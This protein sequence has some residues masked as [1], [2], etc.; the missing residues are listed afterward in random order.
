M[1]VLVTGH[2][3]YVG[4]HVIEVFRNADWIVNGVDTGW[5]N[6]C[7]WADSPLPDEDKIMDFRQLE[8]H[9][10]E[11]FDCIVHLAA[12]SNDALGALDE[13][14]TYDINLRGSIEL[15]QKAK[16][17]GVPR[18]LMAASC[19]V[20]G[21][22][23]HL[24]LDE[25]AP[26]NPLTAYAR[27]KI[28][29]E[30][31][32]SMLA[33]AHFSPAFLRFGTAYGYSP[34]LRLDLVVNNL[35]ASGLTTGEIQIHSDG[36][37]WRPLIHC[38]DMARAFLAFAEAPKDFI[39]NQKINVGSNSENYQVKKIAALI[40]EVLPEAEIT[41]TGQTG[42]DPRSYRVKFDKLNKLLPGFQ[43]SYDLRKG[44]VELYD[45]FVAHSFSEND[46]NS[47]RFYRLRW[48]SERSNLKN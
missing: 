13:Q 4:P 5:F 11:G 34:M 26:L 44:I 10:L 35:L 42:Y 14:Q 1:K 39:H 27:S 3:G 28:E 17:A 33:D 40:K 31:A 32:I 6:N 18:F 16:K 46:F 37:P 48:L 7:N 15:A 12:L 21:K 23:E 43:L 38:R 36:E 41:F 24:D 9:E 29:A 8:I 20:Y 22:G 45:K 2:R 47:P 19:S 25:D 30:E